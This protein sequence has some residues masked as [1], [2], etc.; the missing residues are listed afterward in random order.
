MYKSVIIASSS[1]GRTTNSICVLGVE[2]LGSSHFALVVQSV[3]NIMSD[4]QFS[5]MVVPRETPE[6]YK[7]KADELRKYIRNEREGLSDI[8]MR[9]LMNAVQELVELSK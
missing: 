1:N 9:Q 2:S 3:E 4:K 5:W 8:S 7:R 6:S